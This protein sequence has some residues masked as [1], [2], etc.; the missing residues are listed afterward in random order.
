[1]CGTLGVC[2]CQTQTSSLQ[3]QIWFSKSHRPIGMPIYK[4]EPGVLESK[5]QA[6]TLAVIVLPAELLY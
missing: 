2:K 1:M 4:K 6:E 3:S 5:V